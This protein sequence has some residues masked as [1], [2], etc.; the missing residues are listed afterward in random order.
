MLVFFL[1]IGVAA[2]RW[3]VVIARMRISPAWC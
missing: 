1:A 3:G 2:M